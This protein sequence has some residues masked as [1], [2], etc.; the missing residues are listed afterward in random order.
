MAGHRFTSEEMKG[1]KNAKKDFTKEMAQHVASQELYWSIR[2]CSEMSIKELREKLKAGEFENESLFTYQAINKAI[3]GDF[4]ALQ[5]LWEMA[6]GRPKQQ[7]DDGMSRTDISIN[8][9]ERD[10]SL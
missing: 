4:K 10:L 9:N 8:I 7:I 2:Q 5:W 6:I 1:N 3:K